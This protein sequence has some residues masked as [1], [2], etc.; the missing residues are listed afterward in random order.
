MNSKKFN[1]IF[2]PESI[3]IPDTEYWI[4]IDGQIINKSNKLLRWDINKYNYV[5][6][7]IMNLQNKRIHIP[8]AETV[9]SL[10]YRPPKDDE[11]IFHINGNKLDNH[12]S[13]LKWVTKKEFELRNNELT[14]K[15]KG[16]EYKHVHKHPGFYCKKDGTIIGKR[17]KPLVGRIDKCGYRQVALSENGITKQKSVHRLILETFN[18]IPNMENFQVNHINGNKLDNRLENLEWCT[19]SENLLH[20]YANGL[21]KK[22]NGFNHWRH[23]FTKEQVEDIRI[24]CKPRIKGKCITDFAKKYNCHVST[25]Q[26]CLR[27][28]SYNDN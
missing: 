13:N 16:K 18:P 28:E 27:G 8:I 2:Y 4:R 21:E 1:G 5:R 14:A 17:G 3:Q 9:A 19:R 6:V 26:R 23:A 11:I 7:S 12:I 25:I 15:T 22:R 20:A 10:F 24:N